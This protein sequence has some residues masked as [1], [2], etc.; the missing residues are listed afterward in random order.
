M[1]LCP[2]L[3][4]SLD[5]TDRQPLLLP[6]YRLFILRRL[7]GVGLGLVLADQPHPLGHEDTRGAFNSEMTQALGA[8]HTDSRHRVCPGVALPAWPA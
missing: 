7:C 5:P 2:W 3:A 4:L 1:W 6:V 8:H